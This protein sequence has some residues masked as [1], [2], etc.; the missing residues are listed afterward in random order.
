MFDENKNTVD[1]FNEMAEVY[2]KNYMNVDIYQEPLEYLLTNLN[3]EDSILDLACG[4]GN[5]VQYLA[6]KNNNL[7]LT[8]LD[9]SDEMIRLAKLNVPKAKFEVADC[10][11]LNHLESRYNAIVCNFL[12]P[13]LTENEIEKL[14]S[15]VYNLLVPNGIFYLGFI[16]EDQNRLAIVKS[17]KGHNVSVNYYSIDFVTKVLHDNKF[18]IRYSKDFASINLNQEQTDFIIIASK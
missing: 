14:F 7:N 9:L 11:D 8:G 16:T 5:V 2:Q 6:N 18:F 3:S 10:R 4:P 15:E 1:V 12:L 13:Y 17:S